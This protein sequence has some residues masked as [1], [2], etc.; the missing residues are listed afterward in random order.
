MKIDHITYIN[1]H[2]RLDKKEFIEN[3]LDKSNIN[4]FRTEGVTF[5]LEEE[6]TKS[7]S[8]DTLKVLQR[9]HHV[10]GCYTAHKNAINSLIQQTK[11]SDGYCLIVEDDLYIHDN[12]WEVVKNRLTE[13][14][15]NADVILFD[16]CN[17]LVA[18]C[19]TNDMVSDKYPVTYRI[20]PLNMMFYPHGPDLPRMMFFGTHCVAIHN[21]KLSYI[22]DKLNNYKEVM[23][24]DVFYMLHP[25]IVTYTL[26]TNLVFQDRFFDT[27]IPK[28]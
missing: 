9:E 24:I 7:A 5:S 26:Q 12:F 10:L 20:Q 15:D 13:Q 14:L 6:R 28:R 22:Y 25:D 23:D 11:S 17:N 4:Y 27:D 8:A 19:G 21:S 1:M 3:S 16:S 18:P 2:Y